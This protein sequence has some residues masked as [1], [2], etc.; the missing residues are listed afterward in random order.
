MS[1]RRKLS[2]FGAAS[3]GGGIEGVLRAAL[4]EIDE[5]G[6]LV[7]DAVRFPGSPSGT[8]EY[9]VFSPIVINKSVLIEG[10][11]SDVKLVNK[12]S[13]DSVFHVR[14]NKDNFFFGA[15]NLLFVSGTGGIN[16]SGTYVL[17]PN[18]RLNNVSFH[19]Q[20]GR[21]VSVQSPEL[22]LHFENVYVK[23][24]PQYG[25]YLESNTNHDFVSIDRSKIDGATIAGL[26]FQKS[27]IGSGSVVVSDCE[28]LNNAQ[29]LVV[30]NVRYYEHNVEYIQNEAN[31]VLSGASQRLTGSGGGGGGAGVTDHGQ[32]TGLAD[33]DHRIYYHVSGTNNIAAELNMQGFAI[34]N[35]GTVDS[36]DISVDGAALDAHILDTG[37]PHATSL[38][39]LDPGTLAELNAVIIDGD[40]PSLVAHN[41]LSGTFQSFSG[42]MQNF[43]SS[44]YAFSASHSSRHSSG[45]GDPID[46]Q[47]LRSNGLGANLLLMTNGVGGLVTLSTGTLGGGGGSSGASPLTMS[48]AMG[49]SG[50]TTGNYYTTH[51]GPG[52]LSGSQTFS[53]VVMGTYGFVREAITKRIFGT[54]DGLNNGGWSFH[55]NGERP[56]MTFTSGSGLHILE[57]F[58]GT[59]WADKPLQSGKV[60]VLTYVYNSSQVMLYWNGE[61]AATLTPSLSSSFTPDMFATPAIGITPQGGQWTSPF[62]GGFHGA[63]YASATALSD[64]DVYEH[65]FSCSQYGILV[66]GAFG[67]TNMWT[68]QG[69]A[70]APATLPDTIGTINFSLTGALQMHQIYS[71]QWS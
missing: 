33:N 60:F 51:P 68:M 55:Q 57:N 1:I 5:G 10:D 22:N 24:T 50:T 39:N 53:A 29:A 31:Y 36:R 62:D 65:Y 67:F 40:V 6:V 63:L 58:V 47:N 16:I 41:T 11:S 4:D 34:T 19:H 32:L 3:N 18:S 52:R 70:A 30:N 14:P 35:V 64:R 49:F 44:L 17:S 37:N 25:I 54:Y 23:G 13:G 26:F 8:L 56:R 20:T 12:T 21:A 42:T 43:T 27:N 66:S 38:G 2:E 7:F 9:A 46:I 15:E 45:S 48:I 61:I 28:F 71:P 69:Y 59:G